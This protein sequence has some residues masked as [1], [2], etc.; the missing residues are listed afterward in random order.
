MFEE[1]Y[2]L[3]VSVIRKLFFGAPVCTKK[4][5]QLNNKIDELIPKFKITKD[6][7][8]SLHRSEMELVILRSHFE[9]CQSLKFLLSFGIVS[10]GWW[11]PPPIHVFFLLSTF[12][13]NRFQWILWD[14]IH[15]NWHFCFRWNRI[16]IDCTNQNSLSNN[17]GFRT[18]QTKW[19]NELKNKNEKMKT[20]TY[21][22]IFAIE[23]GMESRILRLNVYRLSDE[24][25]N[26]NLRWKSK[27]KWRE[28]RGTKKGQ[29]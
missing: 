5:N 13:S 15:F 10:R 21:S 16:R 1:F 24:T 6:C 27:G 22:D 20:F 14:V 9:F 3:S 29:M 8:T 11:I 2:L 23:C 19:M 4:K 7:Q 12:Y 17:G 25:I 28:E 26:W 18:V